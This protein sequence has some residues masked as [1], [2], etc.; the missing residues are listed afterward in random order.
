M[1]PLRHCVARGNVSQSGRELAGVN[2]SVRLLA[3]VPDLV[4]KS[5]FQESRVSTGRAAPAAR[6][7]AAGVVRAA[8]S[9]VAF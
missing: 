2:D 5:T 8:V 9:P 6:P 4:V 1:A 3:V 7:L